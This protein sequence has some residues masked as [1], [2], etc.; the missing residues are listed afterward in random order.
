MR[1]L[2]I[3]PLILL[4][5]AVCS[6]II[7]AASGRNGQIPLI[8]LAGGVALLATFAAAV[9]LFLA[10]GASQIGMAQ[11]ALVSTVLHLFISLALGAGILLIV[12]P[13]HAYVYWLLG[14]Y[15]LTLVLVATSA[16]RA[17]RAAQPANSAANR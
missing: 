10:R 13:H 5:T 11:A 7:C 3:N 16:A 1:A 6:A 4:A 15:W 2:L 14:F 12:K 9:P 17:V 8:A